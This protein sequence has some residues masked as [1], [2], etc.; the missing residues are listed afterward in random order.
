V[1]AVTLLLNS[2]A[3]AD[4]AN[5]KGTT[6]LMRASQEGHLDISS[7]LI[8]AKADVNRKNHEGMNALMLASQRGHAAM[9]HLLITKGAVM[10]EQTSQGSTALMLACKRGHEKCVEVLV[11]MGAE[12]YIR[13]TRGR[14][15]RDTATRRSFGNLLA[16]L[17]TQ[18]QVRRIQE[19][20]RGQRTEH[21]LSLRG[22]QQ[23]GCLRLSAADTTAQMLTE[24]VK[25]TMA[26]EGPDAVSTMAD[27]VVS[28][29]SSSSSSSASSSASASA[30]SSSSSSSKDARAKWR[31][32]DL[33]L[34]EAQDLVARPEHRAAVLAIT[35]AL[36]RP[37][38]SPEGTAAGLATRPTGYVE[39]Q[40]PT[41]LLRCMDLPPGLF[42]LI[43]DMLPLPR[44]WQWSLSRLKKR[45]RLSPHQAIHDLSI[46]MDEIVTDAN[47]FAG[48]DQR[49][50][51]VRISRNPS[52]TPAL[53]EAWGVTQPLLDLMRHWSDVQSLVY[54]TGEA[55]VTFRSPIARKMLNAASALYKW[56]RYRC[57]ST[58]AL[59][60]VQSHSSASASACAMDAQDGTFTLQHP[61][62]HFLLSLC[63]VD[64][65][66]VLCYHTDLARFPTF[67]FR[68]LTHFHSC[69]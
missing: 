24:A 43:V 41:L 54:R 67:H 35:A 36:T 16:Y 65:P 51:L 56:H 19:Y 50:H 52:L 58:K 20:R 68:R 25:M 37:D 39:W 46:L 3:S 2:Q 62:R 13:D 10:D 23:R 5:H 49:A 42:E 29:S 64:R 57:S 53:L 34:D 30:S 27:C 7:L 26:L 22:A 4:F 21:L 9:V 8:D 63:F 6:A 45:A 31:P 61:S 60:L 32:P 66:S 15:A 14:T 69:S 59:G 55:D 33:S 48:R 18:V 1:D 47:I 28:S 44:V 12:I 11:S 38:H 17:D 40:W